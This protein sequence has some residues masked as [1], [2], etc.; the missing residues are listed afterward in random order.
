MKDR[1]LVAFGDMIGSE[2]SGAQLTK[3]FSGARNN[4]G[5]EL[6]LESASGGV[7]DRDVHED[8]RSSVGACAWYG[9]RSG[10]GGWI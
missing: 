7:A 5:E 6:H 2:F 8:D 10:I 3:V 4:V 9:C 1:V